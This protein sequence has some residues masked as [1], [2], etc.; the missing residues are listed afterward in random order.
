MRVHTG[1]KPYKCYICGKGHKQK[2]QL[3]VNYN[4]TQNVNFLTQ[5]FRSILEV[6]TL[7]N[8]RPDKFIVKIQRNAYC[9]AKY[10]LIKQISRNIF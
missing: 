4:L 8:G 6:I 2:G 5:I 1:E 7:V 3:K 10:V 9:V